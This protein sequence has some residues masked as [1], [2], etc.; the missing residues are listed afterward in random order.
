MKLQMKKVKKSRFLKSSFLGTQLS[1]LKM[2]QSYYS[3]LMATVNAIALLSL[4]FH[5]QIWWLLALF[6][7]LLIGTYG[8]GYYM[9]KHNINS[10]DSLKSNEMVHRFVN[11]SDLKTQEF[12]LLQT[13]IILES[14][15]AIQDKKEINIDELENQYKAYLARWKSPI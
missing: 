8:I 4:A 1:R 15:K 11:T 14:L 13:R 12:Q 6:P 3:I 9:D 2:G 5:I 7:V 10:I